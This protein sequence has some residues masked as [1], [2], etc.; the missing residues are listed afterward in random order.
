M[1]VESQILCVLKLVA[2]HAIDLHASKAQ[3]YLEHISPCVLHFWVNIQCYIL[4]DDR[5][6]NYM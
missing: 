5:H 4:L 1:R 6:C 3:Y 2:I